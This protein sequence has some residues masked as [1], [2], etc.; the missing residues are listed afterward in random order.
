MGEEI[1]LQRDPS[2]TRSTWSSDHEQT[3]SSS[4]DSHIGAQ[5]DTKV[6]APTK[7]VSIDASTP[8]MGSACML[9]V[10]GG[11]MLFFNTWGIL[12]AFGVFQT[13]YES[14]AHFTV[15]SSDIS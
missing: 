3:S 14:G 9:Q 15:S 5:A 8:P 11:F 6:E 1:T 2:A 4:Q 7:P 10:L 13:F 12:N